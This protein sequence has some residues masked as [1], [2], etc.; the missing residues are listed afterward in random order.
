MKA[1]NF[2]KMPI[3]KQLREQIE[4]KLRRH[5]ALRKH[6]GLPV[7]EDHASFFHADEA[8]YLLRLEPGRE[9]GM[10]SGMPAVKRGTPAVLVFFAGS[11]LEGGS[12]TILQ[13]SR[14]RILGGNTF[15]LHARKPVQPRR[16]PEERQRRSR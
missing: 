11:R 1:D 15:I 16:A 13:D 8:P 5:D 7:H 12:V 9:G 3:D 4:D 14:Q 2:V 6:A 10:L